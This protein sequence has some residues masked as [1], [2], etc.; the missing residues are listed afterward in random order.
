[1]DDRYWTETL[2]DKEGAGVLTS[3]DFNNDSN[4]FCHFRQDSA[5][6]SDWTRHRGT[7]PTPGTGPNGDYP[8][9]SLY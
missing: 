5:D 8:D 9:G 2:T 7:T 4:P 6:N 1:M 3:C